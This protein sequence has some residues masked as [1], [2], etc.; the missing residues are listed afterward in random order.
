MIYYDTIG[1]CHWLSSPHNSHWTE[2]KKSLLTGLTQND[3]REEEADD[4]CPQKEHYWHDTAC[5]DWFKAA[6]NPTSFLHRT[7]PWCICV[8]RDILWQ[9]TG[10]RPDELNHHTIHLIYKTTVSVPV[11]CLCDSHKTGIC[12]RKTSCLMITS[13]NRTSVAHFSVKSAI[14]RVRPLP[15]H[16]CAVWCYICVLAWH[17][18]TIVETCE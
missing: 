8:C 18:I 4:C 15:F 5:T 16:H 9:Q 17:Q 1:W 14:S 7:N 13:S 6:P 11:I 12:E 2:R 10:R 3:D